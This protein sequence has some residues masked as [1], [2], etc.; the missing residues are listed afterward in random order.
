M[1]RPQEIPY[2]S[3]FARFSA[4][5]LQLDLF[6]GTWSFD[7]IAVELMLS[8]ARCPSGRKKRMTL[9]RMCSLPLPTCPSGY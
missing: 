5:R 8:F 6:V 4:S 2:H 3:C 1:H 7:H 9:N